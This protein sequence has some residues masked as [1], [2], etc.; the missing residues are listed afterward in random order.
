MGRHRWRE[1]EPGPADRISYSYRAAGPLECR[2]EP[3]ASQPTPLAGGQPA[4]DLHAQN[5]PRNEDSREDGQHLHRRHDSPCTAFPSPSI[6]PTRH[7]GGWPGRNS[8]GGSQPDGREPEPASR[9]AQPQPT[10]STGADTQASCRRI[11][12]HLHRLHAQ[13][14][15]RNEDSRADGQHLHR[16]HDSPVR[17]SLPRPS[18]RHAGGWPGPQ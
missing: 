5:Q 18:S 13:N 3:G 4:A 10:G 14:R 6:E 12:R 17:P 8:V 15:A 7:A 16:L 1:P 11:R 2:R 9:H